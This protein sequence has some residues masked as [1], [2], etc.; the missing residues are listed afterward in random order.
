ML[1]N[2]LKRKFI[3]LLSWLIFSYFLW[4]YQVSL[5][6]IGAAYL[7]GP[8]L[9]LYALPFMVF[10]LAES[11]IF[12]LISSQIAKWLFVLFGPFSFYLIVYFCIR[13]AFII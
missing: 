11:R 2:Q 5:D 9:S 3:E 1:D 10:L 8:F 4:R 6:D 12:K 7:F 13:L